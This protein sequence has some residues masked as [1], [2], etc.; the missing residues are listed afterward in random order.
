MPTFAAD[1]MAAWTGGRWTRIPGGP[2][3]GFTQD[4]RQLAAGQVFVALKTGRRD[5]HD[6]LAEA[7]QR[8]ATAALVDRE[9]PATT[10][11]QLVVG[12]TLAAFQRIAREHR[13]EFHGTVVGVSGSVGKTS[14]K[15]L[16][17]LLLGGAPRVL[18]TEGN[19][20][21]HLGVPLTLTRLDPAVHQA[22]VIEAGIS[23]PGDMAPL[24]RMIE[25]EHS[26]I[27]LVAPAHLEKLGSLDVVAL[28]KSLLPAANRP[29]GQAVFPVS[30]WAFESFRALNNPLVLVPENEGMTKVAARTIRFNVFH[31]PERTE[32]T[33]DRKRRFLLRRV[34]S[35]MAQNAALALALA[36]ELGI[37]DAVLQTRLADW[38]PSKWRGELRPFGEATVY[39]DFY[40]ANPASMADA[41]DA[42]N[43]SVPQALPRLYV[44]GCMEELGEA[45][46]LYHRQL[47]RLLH[48]RR[49]DFLCVLGAQAEALREGLLENGNDPAAVAVITDLAP[50]RAR[51]AGYQGAVFLKGSRRYQLETVLEPHA[52]A[53][54]HAL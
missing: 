43:G 2:V 49:G 50:V 44:L 21:N 51:L 13:R 48:L 7:Q 34:S 27:T 35:G 37:S 42:F 40:N 47:G 33:L 17:A 11:P 23:A 25:P 53:H 26:V 41:I 36:G 38:A 5:G 39:C 32:V 6:F 10:L 19:L 12:D 20:N 22:A 30:C 28:E 45:S 1:K 16:L 52:T 15:D 46:L 24:A 3:G 8:G 9:I 29:G 18:A 54:A 31:R 4:T 14:T